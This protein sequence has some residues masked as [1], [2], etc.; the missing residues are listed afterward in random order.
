MNK[1]HAV[2]SISLLWLGSLFGAGCAFLTQV[3]LARQLGPLDF[4]IFSTALVTT[5]LL[6]PLAGF[7]IAAYWLK[8]FGE[9]GW[10]AIRWLKGSFKFIILTTLVV[11]LLLISWA[12]F[13]PNDSL[14]TT[15]LLILTTYILG[16]VT[17][18]LVSSKFQLEEHYIGLA[19]WQFSPHLSRL[20][21]IALLIY[22]MNNMT[23]PQMV[24]YAY[25]GVSLLF[26]IIGSI[27]LFQMYQ[28]NFSLAG[29]N[30]TK[31][32][33]EKNNLN[34]PRML[35]IAAQ[36]WPFGLAGI[37]YLIYYQSDI[38][39]LNYLSSPKS[40]G[41]Y[42]VAFTVMA[43]VYLLP[44]V[45]YQK[46]ILSKLHRWANHD[47]RQFY[48]TYKIGNI[49]MLILG[50]LTMLF[51]WIIVPIIIP[52]LFGTAYQNSVMLLI[53]LS[54][55]VPIRFLASNAASILTARNFMKTKIKIMGFAALFNIFLNI[56]FI[57]KFDAIGAVVSTLITEVILF[58]SFYFV[59]N[60][61]IFNKGITIS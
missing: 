16:Q 37:F 27:F 41:I 18:E 7:G 46:F 1:K 4:G 51:L 10:R 9:E 50:I 52:L 29:H 36:S 44:N 57:P 47:Y 26:L 20:L 12:L 34:S 39:L 24:S 48:H 40:A 6:A 2:K 60:K 56:I 30:N 53:I 43:A 38:I 49:F 32:S 23:T 19:L 3:L 33:T 5:N 21:L 28:G 15:L 61:L 13:G 42:N 11:L 22:I 17:I 58:I 55:A 25:A 54:F 31:E 14:A 59:V 45:I 35:D 8:V